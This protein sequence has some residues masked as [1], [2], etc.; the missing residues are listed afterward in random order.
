MPLTR[1]LYELDE[2]IAALQLCLRRNWPRYLFWLHELIVSEETAAAITALRTAWLLWAG[3]WDPTV[4]TA[5]DAAADATAANWIRAANRIRDAIR[6]AGS[7]NAEHLLAEADPTRSRPHLTPPPRTPVVAARRAARSAAFV[8]T[9][10]PGEELSLRDAADFWIALDA[11]TRQG[12]RRDTVWLIQ[13]AQ[14]QM[15][16]DAIWTA[17]RIAARGG[18]QTAAAIATLRAAATPHPDSQLLHQIAAALLLC[19]RGDEARTAML[20]APNSRAPITTTERDWADWDATTGRRAGRVHAIP[21]DALH[22][23][24]TRGQIS[25]KYTNIADIREPVPALPTATAWWRRTAAAAGLHG[26]ETT[27][28][29]HF[30]DDDHLE[31]FF[32]AHFPD[33][34]PDEWSAAD[35]QKSHGRG[36]AETAP[37]PP[38]VVA[39][40]EPPSRRTWRVSICCRPLPAAPHPPPR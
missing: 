15:T 28:A 19:A 24:T 31:A 12:Y 21:A 8:A 13:A 4:L 36:C 3:G 25:E 23:G 5:L 11:A 39:W 30:P 18:P 26:D 32:A 38:A 34:I 14:H 1:N 20:A 37:P 17:L 6:A 35:Q 10:K 22:T 40:A 9:L 33:D 2:V 27:G 16:A 7:L 29:R